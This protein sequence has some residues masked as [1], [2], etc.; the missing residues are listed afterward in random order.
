VAAEVT[1]QDEL[2]LS[3]DEK[4]AFFQTIAERVFRL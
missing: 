2:P 4:K 1:A 3:P